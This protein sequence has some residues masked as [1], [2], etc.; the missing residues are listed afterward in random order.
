[1]LQ[2]ILDRAKEPST[3]AGVATLLAA[4][5]VPYNANLFHAGVTAA[6]AIAGLI[7][8]LLPEGRGGA[9]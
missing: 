7:A 5:G 8:M 9:R 4:A 6:V 2:F 1:M 3:Y